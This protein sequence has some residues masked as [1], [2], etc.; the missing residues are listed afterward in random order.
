MGEQKAELERLE[1][2]NA[3]AADLEVQKAEALRKGEKQYRMEL[4]VLS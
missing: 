4:Q 1:K 3:E 2:Q